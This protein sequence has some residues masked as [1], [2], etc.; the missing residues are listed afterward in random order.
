MHPNPKRNR[1]RSSDPYP[2]RAQV[3]RWL[4]ECDAGS[5]G[6]QQQQQQGHE[7]VILTLSQASKLLHECR[8]ARGCNSVGRMGFTV[9]MGPRRCWMDV[10]V[11]PGRCLEELIADAALN[12]SRAALVRCGV[13]VVGGVGVGGV[14]VVLVVGVGVSIGVGVV[15]VGVVSCDM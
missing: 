4:R 1:N 13:G 8:A 9:K 10:R 11:P 2:L 7:G 14:G 15:S 12:Q 3:S 5:Y 6:A